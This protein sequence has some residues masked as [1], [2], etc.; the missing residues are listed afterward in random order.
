MISAPTRF[1]LFP[2]CERS[3]WGGGPCEAG[4]RG[5]TA[6]LP[7]H[8]TVVRL[9]L[10]HRL[11]RQGGQTTRRNSDRERDRRQGAGGRDPGRGAPRDRRAGR[12]GRADAGR[13]VLLGPYPARG[14]AGDRQDLPRAML[15]ADAGA[16]FRADPVHPG[17]DA[18]RHTGLQPVQLPDQPVHADPGADLL[19]PAAR[20]RDQPHP[21]QDPGRPARGDAGAQR[22]D[23]RRDPPAGAALHGD[24]DP[25]SDRAA[26]RLSAARGAARPVPVQA[27]DGLSVG[28]GGEEDRRRPRRPLRRAAS[29]GLG[30]HAEGDA[31]ARSRKR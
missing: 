20:R 9:P 22:D 17:P 27:Q 19:R 29:R 25:E 12:G 3:S 30:D 28:R 23:R 4:W 16:R 24:R 15:R 13:P 14:A 26:G 31:R 8:R 21:A 5:V 6:D 11:R 2:P 18:G 10:S 1:P 7:L